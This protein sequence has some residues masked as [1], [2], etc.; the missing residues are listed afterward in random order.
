MGGARL[1]ARLFDERY[2][3]LWVSHLHKAFP[4]G[5]GDGA[6]VATLMSD[7]VPFRNRLAHHETILPR[8]I[9]GHHEEMPR[10]SALID[11]HARTWIES[12]SRVALRDQPDIRCAPGFEPCNPAARGRW[13]PFS[14]SD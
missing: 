12:V 4:T 2:H 8:T 1:L 14:S 7:L 5:S 3:Q 11:P 6:E 9:R 13:R 10:L